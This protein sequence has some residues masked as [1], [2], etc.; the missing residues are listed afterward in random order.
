MRLRSTDW[1]PRNLKIR[2]CHF[3][4]LE[5]E[6]LNQTEGVYYRLPQINH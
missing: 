5:S 4:G 3:L 2:S 6:P 1:V